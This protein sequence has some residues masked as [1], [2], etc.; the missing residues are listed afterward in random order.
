VDQALFLMARNANI[1]RR[2]VKIHSLKPKLSQDTLRH[3]SSSYPTSWIAMEEEKCGGKKFK[4]ATKV[5]GMDV[6]SGLRFRS[7]LDH[8]KIT[9]DKLHLSSEIFGQRLQVVVDH[10]AFCVNW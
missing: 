5:D 2:D 10:A 9:M 8:S 7:E 1:L 4:T 6:P 3:F